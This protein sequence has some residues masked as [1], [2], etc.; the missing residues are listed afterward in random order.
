M[1]TQDGLTS[2]E[3]S[4]LNDSQYVDTQ[5]FY[6]NYGIT[7]PGY[8]QRINL[9]RSSNAAEFMSGWN[10]AADQALDNTI[11]SSIASG[12]GFGMLQGAASALNPAHPFINMG[13]GMV[14]SLVAPEVARVFGLMEQDP[15]MSVSSLTSSM[16]AETIHQTAW[17][18][19]GPT[20]QGGFRGAS[21]DA[22]RQAAVYMYDQMGTMGFQ[23]A[24][25]VGMMPALGRAGLLDDAGNFDEMINKATAIID[26]ISDFMKR[27]GARIE[28]SIQYLSMGTALGGNVDQAF[29][30]AESLANISGVTGTPM[31]Q[32]LQ[33]A[34]QI[35]QPFA[36][37]VGDRT[38]LMTGFASIAGIANVAQGY[39][40]YE[41]SFD[42]LGGPGGVGA[43][44]GQVGLRRMTRRR[45]AQFAAA[46]PEDIYDFAM[47]GEI[48][49]SISSNWEGMSRR[50]RYASYF[51]SDEFV[52]DNYANLA[53]G[54][55]NYYQSKWDEFN[56]ET[57]EERAGYMMI[58]ANMS[59]S[60]AI[61]Y[62]STD[63]TD[64]GMA[65]AALAQSASESNFQALTRSTTTARNQ[66]NEAALVTA[67][68]ANTD[69]LGSNRSE[70]IA[71]INA[72]RNVSPDVAARLG[73][74]PTDAAANAGRVN[75]ADLL[76]RRYSSQAEAEFMNTVLSNLGYEGLDVSS[77]SDD[78]GGFGL[79]GGFRFNAEAYRTATGGT[80]TNPLSI[81]Y[82]VINQTIDQQAA[83]ATETVAM[84][85]EFNRQS[86]NRS[87]QYLSSNED[88]VNSLASYVDN[89]RMGSAAVEYSIAS[90][91]PESVPI[92]DPSIQRHR[93]TLDSAGLINDINQG[94]IT[95]HTQLANRISRNIFDDR[96]YGEL[97][98]SER[99]DV[100]NIMTGVFGQYGFG[101]E[102]D[103]SGLFR[104]MSAERGKLLADES[105]DDP[106]ELRAARVMMNTFT[107]DELTDIRTGLETGIFRDPMLAADWSQMQGD[108]VSQ[109]IYSDLDAA[110]EGMVEGITYTDAS[111]VIGEASS[112]VARQIGVNEDDFFR[113]VA[114][115]D[116]AEV[117]ALVPEGQ[118]SVWAD[119]IREEE[120]VGSLIEKAYLEQTSGGAVSGQREG[121]PTT[122]GEAAA[123]TETNTF[124]ASESLAEIKTLLSGDLNVIVT[125][126]SSFY[127]QLR[128]NGG[129]DG[130]PPATGGPR[131]Y[132]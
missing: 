118:N 2:I 62:V 87:L 76:S 55:Y 53:R 68:R 17:N 30:V 77:M 52:S 45:A 34:T 65:M 33:Y 113:A 11:R 119:I 24:E 116:I 131:N 115:N 80:I 56:L 83:L 129:G 128:G 103:P 98:R 61:A 6:N 124:N 57:P 123:A 92:Y 40:D 35:A 41:S 21:M 43:M 12:V 26:K 59:G 5:Q 67:L 112:Y 95:S 132:E 29:G 23:G 48:P 79:T 32:M 9:E 117:R 94:D 78:T 60:E 93:A 114:S 20:T 88:V 4:L 22:A 19:L 72:G 10:T 110:R 90:T 126:I 8:Q 111:I 15:L 105:T 3:Q 86:I 44:V 100:G 50:E 37:G 91:L 122:Y 74:N 31:D 109:G 99:Q 89:S 36:M 16:M 28:E 106:A 75:I 63:L 25:L 13:I 58:E 49:G 18:I 107:V 54:E 125:N 102:N 97:N 66:L 42:A 84:P 82:D 73:I 47:S 70:E 39:S 121:A 38:G 51:R 127:Q 7:A 101:R 69:L 27:T 71:L 130:T 46:D 1:T 96:S 14:G 64:P 120:E 81:S 85:V 104:Q 108:L